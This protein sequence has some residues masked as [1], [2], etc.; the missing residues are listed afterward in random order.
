MNS[1]SSRSH[2]IFTVS[3]HQEFEPIISSSSSDSSSSGD[4]DDANK[5]NKGSAGGGRRGPGSDFLVSRFHFVDLAGSERLK[6]TG[7]KGR[8]AKEGIAI[9]QGLSFLGDVISKLGDT[10]AKAVRERASGNFHIPYRNSKLTRIL[11]D[12]LGGNS[13][14]LMIACVSP[15][16][17]SFDE[18]K[19][20]LVYANR[21]RNIKN[22]PVVNTDPMV[23]L[24]AEL[25]S[26]I[27]LLRGLCASQ[28]RQHG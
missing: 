15:A 19:S 25:K 16:D 22:K 6:R 7:A 1:E 2:A 11:Q 17:D 27:K 3:I 14:T 5:T 9:N 21:A 24:V 23:Q 13:R 4:G 12:S 20:T 10:S 8:R 28:V 26:E 18:T